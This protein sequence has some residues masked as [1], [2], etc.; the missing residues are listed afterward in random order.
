MNLKKAFS[1]LLVVLVFAGCFN[2]GKSLKTAG[3]K[4][5]SNDAPVIRAKFFVYHVDEN[6]SE[7]FFRISTSSLL[8]MRQNSNDNF[9]STLKL[10]YK[11]SDK[12][13]SK[14]VSDSASF[15]IRDT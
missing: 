14:V 9:V 3:K 11:L 2:P 10:N 12:I 7:I 4:F 1:F 5:N 15:I 8:Y 13:V 6:T